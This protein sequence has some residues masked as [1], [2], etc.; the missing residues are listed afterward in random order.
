MIKIEMDVRAAAA[1]RQVLF[2]EQK[3]YTQDPTC[4]PQRISDIREVI[5]S[6]DNEI[7]RELKEDLENETTNT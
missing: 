6:I 1:V 3:I 4:T 5:Y 2:S 7:A